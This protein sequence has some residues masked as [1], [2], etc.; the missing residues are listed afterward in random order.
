[1]YILVIFIYTLVP[2]LSG[3]KLSTAMPPRQNDRPQTKSQLI[4]DMLA[5]FIYVNLILSL[6]NQHYVT[7]YEIKKLFF[8]AGAA[9]NSQLSCFFDYIYRFRLQI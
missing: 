1:L 3:I 5:I 7:P 4:V 8:C 2:E 9:L 6:G